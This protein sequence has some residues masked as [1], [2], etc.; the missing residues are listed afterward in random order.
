MSARSYALHC[1]CIQLSFSLVGESMWREILRNVEFDRDV[2]FNRMWKTSVNRVENLTKC[3]ICRRTFRK[4]D[5]MRNLPPRRKES[6]PWNGQFI[7]LFDKSIELV[8]F[9]YW[10]VIFRRNLDEVFRSV[11]EFRLWLILLVG[12]S[13]N[14]FRSIQFPQ[15]AAISSDIQECRSNH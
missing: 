11:I 6:C 14:Q 10:G 9:Q 1:V 13:A 12:H 8:G 7:V 5:E 3:E 15:I 4:F 2:K